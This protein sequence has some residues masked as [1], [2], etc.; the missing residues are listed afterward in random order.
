MKK[1]IFDYTL[2]PAHTFKF[3]HVHTHTPQRRN[4]NILFGKLTF[5]FQSGVSP[6]LLFPFL[7][8]FFFSETETHVAKASLKLTM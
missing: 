8:S 7:P 3:V 4:S 5:V 6:H 1:A 2:V